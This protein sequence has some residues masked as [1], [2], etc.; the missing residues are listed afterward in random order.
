[1]P[2]SLQ[3]LKEQ[4]YHVW[5][6]LSHLDLAEDARTIFDSLLAKIDDQILALQK[7]N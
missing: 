6:V 2:N 5:W 7:P 3:E 1:M 4:R